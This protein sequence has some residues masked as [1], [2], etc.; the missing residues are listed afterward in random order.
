MSLV[1]PFISLSLLGKAFWERRRGVVRV[2]ASSTKPYTLD[3]K[4]LQVHTVGP[5]RMAHGYL[6]MWVHPLTCTHTCTFQLGN[7]N[8]EDITICGSDILS[9]QFILVLLRHWF[10]VPT[11]WM[12]LP[13]T[14]KCTP[15]HLHC[16]YLLTTHELKYVTL[17]LIGIE[18][19]YCFI[20]QILLWSWMCFLV[21][22][23]NNLFYV[24]FINC[25]SNGWQSF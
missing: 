14:E 17:D 11:F 16:V 3:P 21:H 22:L 5:R 24:Y 19:F 9:F 8:T 13:F 15:Y 18:I 6:R 10:C 2:Q 12:M 1:T 7:K 25:L 4:T 20:I 23:Y